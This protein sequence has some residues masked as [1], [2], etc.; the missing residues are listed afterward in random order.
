MPRSV[1]VAA[2]AVG[3]V[4]VS[5]P[6]APLPEEAKAPV[7]FFP[8]RAVPPMVPRVSVKVPDTP[9]LTGLGPP[10]R[11]LSLSRGVV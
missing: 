10:N 1:L 4:A 2:A 8:T 11:G 5:A 9:M 7:L 6:A 3:L